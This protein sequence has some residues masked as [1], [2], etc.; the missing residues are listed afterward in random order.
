MDDIVE[1]V[2]HPD[3]GRYELTVDSQFAGSL[4]YAIHNGR[5]TLIHTEIDSAY[6]GK[7]LGQRLVRS[8]LED[9][10]VRGLRVRPL[11]PF[12]A[13]YIRS[14]PEYQDLVD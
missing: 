1:T 13:A 6:A 4:T 11:C 14:H 7:H 12:V 3:R 5:I 10:R 2:N 9:A 8:V